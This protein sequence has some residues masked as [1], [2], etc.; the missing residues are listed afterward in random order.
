MI[1]QLWYGMSK[2]Q[3]T[4]AATTLLLFV[5]IVRWAWV[6]RITYDEGYMLDVIAHFPSEHV[7]QV[8]YNGRWGKRWMVTTGPT[9]SLP[10]GLLAYVIGVNVVVARLYVYGL[11]SA[12]FYTAGKLIGLN[13]RAALSAAAIFLLW[14]LCL[15]WRPDINGSSI[16][17]IAN[18]FGE[19]T[20]FIFALLANV[21][22]AQTSLKLRSWAWVCAAL[23]VGAKTLAVLA[24]LCPLGYLVSRAYQK[25]SLRVGGLLGMLAAAGIALGWQAWQ[26]YVLGWDVYLDDWHGFFYWLHHGGGFQTG[27][28]GVIAITL[29]QKLAQMEVSHVSLSV[30][31]FLTAMAAGFLVWLKKSKIAPLD[32]LLSKNVY[33][34][35]AA[36]TGVFYFWFVFLAGR[37]WMRHLWIGYALLGWL[38]AVAT[39]QLLEKHRRLWPAPAAMLAAMLLI[40]IFHGTLPALGP[41]GPTERWKTQR[42]LAATLSKQYPL[43]RLMVSD[44]RAVPHIAF[45]MERPQFDMYEVQPVTGDIFLCDSESGCDPEISKYCEPQWTEAR[46]AYCLYQKGRP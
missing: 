42:E 33:G 46:V 34:L 45:F 9:I 38:F 29:L 14:T 31:I 1:R 21:L 41:L 36:S 12:L 40:S 2:F 6:A 30:V 22:A 39:A 37:G 24:V 28:S 7:M 3:R 27:Q 44:W 20:A 19:G 25:R 17:L 32:E 43:A 18:V 11:V 15:V 23:A 5:G 35:V 4:L 8:V 10:L 16:N 26:L 13:T